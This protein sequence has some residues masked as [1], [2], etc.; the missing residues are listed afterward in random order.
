M[1]SNGKAAGGFSQGHLNWLNFWLLDYRCLYLKEERKKYLFI[2][3]TKPKVGKY[4]KR[5]WTIF[6]EDFSLHFVLNWL[7]NKYL[8]TKSK[9]FRSFVVA[10]WKPQT[11]YLKYSMARMMASQP[12]IVYLSEKKSVWK[13]SPKA[14]ANWIPCEHIGLSFFFFFDYPFNRFQFSS[15]QWNYF[16][17]FF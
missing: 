8:F 17:L 6:G 15:I 13:Y 4:A 14:L 11:V 12:Q 3:K 9:T 16:H 7:W 10:L 1:D 2:K 5:W